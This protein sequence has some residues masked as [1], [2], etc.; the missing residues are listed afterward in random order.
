MAERV[1]GLHTAPLVLQ[2]AVTFPTCLSLTWQMFYAR[3][4]PC[5]IFIL[6][7][8]LLPSHFTKDT[9]ETQSRGLIPPT[10]PSWREPNSLRVLSSSLS[11][12]VTEPPLICF[13]T[14]HSPHKE[15]QLDPTR[16][17]EL[18]KNM[19]ARAP[20]PERLI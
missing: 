4:V 10:Q 14:S 8:I 7:T 15:P 17:G 2:P 12:S 9:S 13:Q 19:D 5:R 3:H 16:P 6:T 18:L 20:S 1:P 11:C